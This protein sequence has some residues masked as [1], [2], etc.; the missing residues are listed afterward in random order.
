MKTSTN[1]KLLLPEGKDPVNIGDITGDF[2]AIDTYLA[3]MQTASGDASKNSVVF[4]QAADRQN[5]AST[6]TLSTIMGKIAKFFTDIKAAAFCAIANNDTT[7]AE[8]Y[9]ADARIVKTHGDEIDALSA[10][11]STNEKNISSLNSNL[12][13]LSNSTAN[14]ISNLNSAN[15]S[16]YTEN[17]RIKVYV[18]SDQKLHFV[19]R[20]GAD[21]ALNFSRVYVD[22]TSDICNVDCGIG[23]YNPNNGNVNTYLSR[24]T[25]SN[26]FTIPKK[27][28]NGYLYSLTY[29][30]NCYYSEQ[31]GG[32]GGASGSYKLLDGSTTISSG[33]CSSSS[34]N[35]THTIDFEES[36]KWA[37]D[38]SLTLSIS[39]TAEAGRG[40]HEYSGSTAG[41]GYKFVAT[42][43]VPKYST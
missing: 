27:S 14:S 38:G 6:E 10:K 42:Y 16:R 26:S 3:N 40:T 37:T 11:T 39:A 18:G 31:Y 22:V 34:S 33:S 28:G 43:K 29:T 23:L 19:D 15:T 21:T 12:T 1:L 2:E 41:V 5:I 13:N 4:A 25:Y 35:S 36:Y 32:S 9:A 30:T 24:K 20:D 17:G 7:T 8:G